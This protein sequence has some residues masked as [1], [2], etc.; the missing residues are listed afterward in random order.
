MIKSGKDAREALLE[1]VNTLADIV[2]T[3]LGP[4]GLNVVLYNQEG[5]AYVT[6]DGISVA[7]KVFSDDPTV[8]A[9]IQLVREASAKTAEV[10]G[11]GTTTSV[12]LAQCLI[13][14]CMTLMEHGGASAVSLKKG[15][16][17]ALRDVV[18]AL[19]E[20]STPIGIQEKE[21][22]DIATLSANND[23]EIGKIV[24]DAFMQAGK[25][26]LV[27]FDSSADENTYTESISGMQ[28]DSQ[29]LSPS[30]INNPRRQVAEYEAKDYNVAVLLI[31]NIVKDANDLANV[32][33]K[34][35]GMQIPVVVVAHEYSIAALKTILQSNVRSNSQILPIK[36]EGFGNGKTESLKDIAALTG[37]TIYEDPKTSVFEGLGGC[38]KI[39]VSKF[40]TTIVKL[41][42]VDSSK[43]NERI[44]ILK[45]RIKEEKNLSNKEQLKKKLAKLI[46]KMQIIHVGGITESIAKEK[47]DRVE[48]AVCATKA[49]IEEGISIGGGMTFWK[50][51][52]KLAVAKDINDKNATGYAAVLEA[53][54]A[55]F[56]QLCENGGIDYKTIELHNGITNEGSDLKKFDFDGY[57]FGKEGFCNMKSRGIID[58][59]KVLRTAIENAVSMA[60]TIITTSGIIAD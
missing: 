17:E 21:L 23:S 35:V 47:Y 46:G 51:Q 41:D 9:G 33:N 32:F 53:L 28:L 52:E 7:R 6:K 59:T 54:R 11:D 29:L 16:E 42:K 15:M 24:A 10:A 56:M 2:K 20:Y 40:N 27:L 18:G 39:I 12:I 8:E 38:Q 5:K 36:A 34:T 22:T 25:D 50:I 26:G 3:T 49:A 14:R 48:D 13:N 55:P 30:F 58:P 37:A 43:L 31:D 1:G 45:S 44:E 4:K 19:N 60:V 57:D